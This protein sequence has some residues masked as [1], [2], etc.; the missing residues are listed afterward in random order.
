MNDYLEI[1][2][3]VIRLATLQ[4]RHSERFSSAPGLREPERER[5]ARTSR[6][7]PARG[8]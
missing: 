6:R 8:F 7:F 2:S 5:I 4:P 3:D 1:F